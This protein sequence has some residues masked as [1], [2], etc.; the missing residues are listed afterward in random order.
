VSLES[1]FEDRPQAVVEASRF[2]AVLLMNDAM[3]KKTPNCAF[4][5][6]SQFSSHF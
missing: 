1:D 2:N 6:P 3:S 4:W 5:V